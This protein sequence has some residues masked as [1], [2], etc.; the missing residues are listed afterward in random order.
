[1]VGGHNFTLEDHERLNNFEHYPDVYT[2]VVPFEYDK[3]DEAEEE[4]HVQT[5][6]T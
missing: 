3:D 1:M 2:S 5:I 6:N 4:Q